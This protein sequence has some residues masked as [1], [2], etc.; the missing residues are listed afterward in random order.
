MC[1]WRPA[2]LHLRGGGRSWTKLV[3]GASVGASGERTGWST[4]V[5]FARVGQRSPP[6][7]HSLVKDRRH[8][9]NC[10]SSYGVPGACFSR[11]R[12]QVC[13]HPLHICT[14]R[15]A[16]SE[17]AGHDLDE[18]VLQKVRRLCTELVAQW[19]SNKISK[20][21]GRFI[22][23]S[24]C[25]GLPTPQRLADVEQRGQEPKTLFEPMHKA[26][27]ELAECKHHGLLN[28]VEDSRGPDHGS[29]VFGIQRPPNNTL[30]APFGPISI[31][32]KA[33]NVG[34]TRLRCSTD[35]GHNS[36]IGH[37]SNEC[38]CHVYRLKKR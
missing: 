34:A 6:L 29:A 18:I 2:L 32:P 10:N 24:H 5:A 25:Q 27:P 28:S 7:L 31:W 22:P 14:R 4:K 33:V 12:G 36:K 37:C 23:N 15:N 13:G 3:P 20:A 9:R 38:E 26:S 1:A 19:P 11:L 35:P 30:P 21:T 8:V 17:H 16:S